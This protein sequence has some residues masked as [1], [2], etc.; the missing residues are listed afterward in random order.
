MRWHPLPFNRLRKQ[1]RG[2]APRRHPRPAFEEL[3][4]RVL[5]AVNVLTYHYDNASTGLNANETLLTPN[6]V[7]PT[8]FGKLFSTPVDG[9][10]YAE[11]LYMAGVSITVGG[12]QGSHN[13]VF[14]ATE[15]DSLYAIDADTGFVLWQDSFLAGPYLPPE[16]T[17][18]TVPSGDVNSSDLTPEI[19]ITSTPVIDPNTNTIY[20]TAKTKEVY[21]GNTHYVY[22]LHA[23]DVSSGAEKFGGPVVIADTISND[24][25]HYTY[26]SGPYVNGTGD[27]R[28][29]NST[30]L[31]GG[32]TTVD[33]TVVFNALRQL[34]RPGLTLANGSVHLAFASHGDNGPYHGWILGYSVPATNGAG[35]TVQLSAVFNTTP[36]GGL[37]GVWQSGGRVAADAQGNLFFETGNGTF[38]TTLNGQGLPV[39]GDYGD[40]FVK[41][42]VDQTTSQTNQGTNGWGLKVVDYF[43]PFNQQ[44]LNDGDTD[45]G[46]GAPLLL[47]DSADYVD[48]NGVSHQLLVGGGKEGWLYVIDRNN[49]GHFDPNTDHVLQ[50]LP[51]AINGVL[52]TPAFFNNT[53][54][55]VGGY[56]DVAK[57]FS[58]TN[59]MLSSS[60]TSQSSDSYGFP[61]STPSISANGTT[62]GIV[63]DLDRSSNQLR[64]YDATNYGTELYTSAQAANNRDQLG[65]VVKFTVPLVANG[66]VYVGTAN[67]L[68]FYGLLGTGTNPPAAPSNLT[69]TAVSSLQIN[70]AWQDH[71]TNETGFLIERSPDGTTFAQIATVGTNVTSYSDTGLA[72][73]T[74]YFYRVRATNAIGDSA[75]S[76][77]ANTTTLQPLAAPWADTDIGNP[78]LAGSASSSNGTFTVNGGGADIWGTSDA[79]HYVYQALSGDGTIVARVV[80]VQNTDGWAKAGVMI[81]ESLN[82]NSTFVDM[83]I[84]P[85]NGAALQARTTTGGSAVH[86]AGPGVSAP[87][88]VELVRSGDT[89]TGFVSADGNSFTQV[90]SYTVSMVADI[91]IGLAVTSHNDG[92]LNTSTFDNVSVSIPTPSP[93]AAPSDMLATG[94]APTQIDLTWTVNSTNESGFLIE[95]STDAVN[96]TQIA[97]AAAWAAAYVVTGLAVASTYAY[98]V[99][100]VNSLGDS[101]YSNTASAITLN[102]V[103]S[104]GMD[105]SGGFAGSGSQLTVNGTAK[106]NG[107]L[108]QLTD[109]GG[110]EAGSVFSTAPVLLSQFTTAFA[111][112][113]LNGTN[114]SADGLTFT[115]QGVGPTAL[116]PSGGGLG[117]GPDH[118]SGSPGI[119]SSVA[120]KFDLY[121]NEGEGTDST[122]LYTDGA[123]P[124]TAGS[125]DLSNTG[126]NL[127]SQ[128]VFD[129]GMSYHGTTLTVAITDASTH[130][131]ATQSYAV[132][133]P[134]L[135]GGNTAYVGFTGGTGGLT[136][137][138]D[139]QT[140]TFA[141]SV[142]PVAPTSL[143]ATPTSGTQ[144]ELTWTEPNSNQ[145]GFAIERSTDGTNYTQIATVGA[146]TTSYLDTGLNTGTQYDYRVRAT[147][148]AGVSDY[149]PVATATTPVPPA[150][151]SNPQTTSITTSEVDLAW[152][153]NSNNE[154]GF[155]VYRRAGANAFSLIAK[156]PANTTSFQD[157]GLSA[158]TTYD[159]HVRAFNIAG[160][161]N[162][163]AISA[164]TVAAAPTGLAATAGPGQ[165]T[166]TW[167][168]STGATSYNIYRAT[169]SG[170]EGSTPIASGVSS[171]SFTDGAVTNGTLYYY[172]VTG[173]DAGGESGPSNESSATPYTPHLG[174]NVPASAAAGSAFT[175]TVTALDPSNHTATGYLG[176]IHFTSSDVGGA[177]V[178]P[179]DYTFVAA[180]A[181]VHTF[182][183]TLVTAGGQTVTATDTLDG[184]ITGSQSLTISPAATSALVVS[185]FPSSTKAGS[186]HPFTVTAVDAY[187]NV[188]PGYT[189][190]VSFS[191]SDPPAAL[192]ADYTFVRA[193]HGSHRFSATLKTAGLQSIT[194]SDTANGSITGTQ[195]GITISPAAVTHLLVTAPASVKPGVAFS[196]T[197]TA[198]DAYGNTVTGYGGTVH[199]S[200]SDTNATL[201]K[202]YEFVSADQGSHTF[203]RRV[204]LRTLGTQTITAT[205]AANSAITGTATVTVSLTAAPP[206]SNSRRADVA[207]TAAPLASA[208][209]SSTATR[210]VELA[211]NVAAVDCVFASA[212]WEEPHAFINAGKQRAHHLLHDAVENEWVVLD[213]GFN[214]LHFRK[215]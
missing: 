143:L 140:W 162:F 192:P 75:Y 67:S 25:S 22:R 11:P 61:G 116:G 168:G 160:L 54:Y 202:N 127:H 23:L 190:T 139:I 136:A 151:P 163:A 109:G 181:G 156:L 98:R 184:A 196:I 39:N 110:G 90:G 42:A 105:F 26:V 193:N 171:T 182:S 102:G 53:V 215:T 199:F 41:L 77:T 13:V 58:I 86:T 178:L 206:P 2:R 212:N 115:I 194:A 99:R 78:G 198:L 20:L 161:S 145:T 62:A 195:S 60:P 95:Q 93:P 175:I 180:D 70:L 51:G 81:R 9:Q 117:Y 126:I 123:A 214:S 79:F 91:Y 209:Q 112:Q 201:P 31:D 92:Q 27:G 134:G 66:T 35:Q 16:A 33:G 83:V 205:A 179:A 132:N 207:S 49:M 120:I 1:I 50:E 204:I 129:V 158:G 191:S 210:S 43:T 107:S 172:E 8:N 80:S 147:N 164:T 3:E 135:V 187:G 103:G 154:D 96:F 46:S 200:S 138:Q 65:S 208:S 18:T 12:S 69:A 137:V 157:K 124:T 36:N 87:Y 47:P 197:V 186:T 40:S 173:V 170:G 30:T 97:E 131:G 130:A 176:T 38:D 48:G 34:Q 56:G 188:T 148:A 6:N 165:V 104:G 213:S 72:S 153:D 88:W 14:V 82:A 101:G 189:G 106:V 155:K 211:S 119:G 74:Q 111:C 45:L 146:N 185:G 174:L 55:Y 118:S 94:V 68:V 108:L 144:I 76:N 128:D 5:L 24:L 63:W 71:S 21:S 183:I 4:P 150:A 121:S 84:T 85:G 114:P 133:I 37:G 73:G 19:G 10:V 159:Y 32:N 28:V 57:A 64:V 125:I 122:G 177:R 44:G 141:P 89:F 15:H 113:I 149:S 152:Q 17:V 52:D 166:L 59:G 203:V 167:T 29:D 7:K 169:T 100:A 142:P